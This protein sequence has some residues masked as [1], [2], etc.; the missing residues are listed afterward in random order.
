LDYETLFLSVEELIPQYHVGKMLQELSDLINN[1]EESELD[2]S[3][4]DERLL[5]KRSLEFEEQITKKLKSDLHIETVL[6][7]LTPPIEK[8]VKLP[9][10]V[11]SDIEDVVNTHNPYT[12]PTLSVDSS[13]VS[14][15]RLKQRHKSDFSRPESSDSNVPYHIQYIVSSLDR[16]NGSQIILKKGSNPISPFKKII[17]KSLNLEYLDLQDLERDVDRMLNNLSKQG[18]VVDRVRKHY[19]YLV[20]YYFPSSGIQGKRRSV[21][22]G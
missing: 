12:T 3:S 9:T 18:H 22:C 16:H 20:G 17:Q 1:E 8:E 14:D 11:E 6:R 10:P 5:Q 7:E 15:A 13:P 19:D 2:S 4:Q 21:K